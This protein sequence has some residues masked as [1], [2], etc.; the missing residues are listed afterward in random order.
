[1]DEYLSFLNHFEATEV[2]NDGSGSLGDYSHELDMSM[3][4]LD[5]DIGAVAP[6][7]PK[8]AT[9]LEYPIQAIGT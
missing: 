2:H 7:I 3:A 9:H 1:M 5:A 6:E 8:D 4:G